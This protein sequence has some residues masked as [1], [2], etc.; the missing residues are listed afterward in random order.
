M[1]TY[2]LERYWPGISRTD[3]EAVIACEAT[4]AETMRGEGRSV[5]VLRSTLVA[6]DE[7]LLS[8]VEAE[9]EY[10]AAELGRRCGVPADRIVPAEDMEGA[11]L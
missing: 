8:L 5:R 3:A 1:P 2:L 4:H 7:V 6:V 11:V 10:D 9:S